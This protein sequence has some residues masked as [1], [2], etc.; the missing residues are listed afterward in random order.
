MAEPCESDPG[1]TPTIQQPAGP[2]QADGEAP[3][4]PVSG[5][6][7]RSHTDGFSLDPA[8]ATVA[9]ATGSQASAPAPESVLAVVGKYQLVEKIAHGGM[10][11]VYRAWD[12]QLGRY[13]ALKMIRAGELAS[14]ADVQ[15]F[16]KEAKAAAQL[17]HPGIVPVFDVGEHEG[18]HYYVMGLVE[19]PS[20]A[21]RVHKKPLPPTEA[22]DVMK[23]VAEAVAYAHGKGIIH[24]DLKPG[25]ILLDEAGQPKV[26][27]FGLA[28]M[29]QDES[30]LTLTGQVVGTAAYMPPEQ[31]AGRS[32][33]VGPVSDVYSLGATLYCLL[34][35]RPPFHAATS[36]ETLRQVLDREPVS[37]RQ[38]NPA[39]DRD[40]ETI[41]LK[42]L[43]K[44]P[45]KR[46]GSAT[47]LAEDLGHR[48]AGEPI[49]ARPISRLE[50]LW[51]W[52]CRNKLVA[53]LAAGIFVSLVA[54]TAVSIAFAVQA[55]R[56]ANL[57]KARLYVAEVGRAYQEWKEGQI[58]M[59]QERLQR[60]PPELRGFEWDYLQRLCQLDL[61]TIHGHAGSANS[62]TF[63]PD[64]RFVASGGDDHTV[65]VWDMATGAEVQKLA[66]HPAGVRV[67][68]ISPSGRWLASAHVDKA[69]VVWDLTTG[70][71]HRELPHGVWGL[72][73]DPKD[74]LAITCGDGT[75]RVM[76]P[77]TAEQIRQ[78]P[79]RQGFVLGMAFSRDGRLLATA[80]RDWTVKVWDATTAKEL[81]CLSGHTGV[82]QGVAF[83]PDGRLLASVSRDTSVR[84]WDWMDGREIRTIYGHQG[85]VWGVAFSRDGRRLAS[86]G[87]D[88]TVKLWET[89]TGK[90]AMTL[91]G[92]R[93]AVR[94]VAFSPD[95][96][97]LASADQE[98][99]LKVWDATTTQESAS[100]H[101]DGQTC[102]RVA[103]SPDG[104][105]LAAAGGRVLMV[106]DLVG[107]RGPLT[108]RGH[109]QIVQGLAFSVNQGW[110]ASVSSSDTDPAGRVQAGEL[111]VWDVATGRQRLRFGGTAGLAQ[112]VAFSPDGRRL[113]TGGQ[114][115]VVRLWD[116]A[117]G[118][119]IRTLARLTDPVPDV[120]F[121][122]DGHQ[123]A[124][125]SGPTVRVWDALSG[126]E[127]LVL[128]GHSALIQ[129][130]AFSPDGRWIA[131]GGNDHTARV[132]DVATGREVHNLGAHQYPVLGVAFSPDSRRLATVASGGDAVKVWDLL[133]EQEIL[134][135]DR[136]GDYCYDIAFSP[137][138]LR[139]AVAGGR[140]RA[141]KQ[142]I[143]IQD[144]VRIW[145][146]RPLTPELLAQVEAE[147]LVRSF[148]AKPSPRRQVLQAIGAD[149]TISQEV[150]D[151]AAILAEQNRN[152]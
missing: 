128:K 104:T 6:R 142:G 23:R 42:C 103:F 73:F 39:I 88:R 136:W 84:I 134:T 150:R 99:I 79:H 131:T 106:W 121:S 1:R 12:T 113:A 59:V 62:I 148:F 114:D 80:G 27:D 122:R 41:C 66:G 55:R 89:A 145:D 115:Q 28:K 109:T 138:G 7:P 61:R 50:R 24:R 112:S 34:T 22:A 116:A 17:D 93:G 74:H 90:E 54:G 71:S 85:F 139:L 49:D 117:T 15:R 20:L 3:S 91:R 16:Y 133:T 10:G 32:T 25:N 140:Y 44:E 149:H 53:S 77:N 126:R 132:W 110:L 81:R 33:V 67:V 64:G 96:W 105:S 19:G 102:Q 30:N 143:A 57:A 141:H 14:E 48:L 18:R 65:G 40:L 108:L 58:Q 46:Y 147:G 95:G 35:G 2:T 127:V 107:R 68:A 36:T 63:S 69:V 151:R 100:V 119:E 52:C 76:D 92:H 75:I 11:V 70:K 4:E 37:P 125:C 87:D 94:A 152:P 21:R 47:E 43:Q 13:V 60:Q 101:I 129:R 51:R 111:I 56:E 124:A 78:W 82:V 98:G 9:Q 130:L 97:R 123:V 146:A 31:A 72:A 8:A 137:D 38:L 45:H 26:T 83:S 86:A 5:E 144:E 120:V 118:G 29:V 135:L